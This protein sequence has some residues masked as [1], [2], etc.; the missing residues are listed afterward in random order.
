MAYSI[1]GNKGLQLEFKNDML[2][3][4]TKK[5]EELNEALKKLG[6]LEV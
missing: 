4:G 2:F 1:S 3:I 5:P 6:L